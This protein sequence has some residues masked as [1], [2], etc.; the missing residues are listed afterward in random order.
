VDAITLTLDEVLRVAANGHD[1]RIILIADY[2]LG[3]DVI[4]GRPELKGIA[5]LR[6]R[7]VGFEANALGAFVLA[8]AL[9]KN[10]LPPNEVKTAVVR[11]D[12]FVKEF[13][14]RKLD[15]VVTF[16]PYRSELLKAGAK[17]LFTSAEIPG[18]IADV[19]VVRKSLLD[20]NPPALRQL[21][22]GW[23][24]ALDHLAAHPA[25]AAAVVAPRE[26][27]TP[28]EF[29]DSLK[30]LRLVDR[31]ENKKLLDPDNPL[32]AEHI[33]RLSAFMFRHNLLASAV[34]PAMLRDDRF[35]REVVK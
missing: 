27:V 30:L 24:R 22:D 9:E 13:S 34:D 5:D 14:A 18:E 6:G 26:K 11:A 19:F 17:E 8:R 23:F 1:I 7:T 20:E 2:S 28:R 10:N 16:E 15:A 35:V 4:M 12:Q 3:G 21:T 25:E 33:R 31:A 32:L 29:L